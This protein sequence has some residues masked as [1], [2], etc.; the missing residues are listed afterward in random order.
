MYKRY[1][2]PTDS[3]KKLWK[4]LE[5]VIVIKL[6]DVRLNKM[7]FERIYI[8]TDHKKQQSTCQQNTCRVT[9]IEQ[10]KFI[11]LPKYRPIIK[12]KFEQSQL[13]SLAVISN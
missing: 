4:Y 3:A 12:L 6:S 9:T 1:S 13:L 10:F 2:K 5:R 7:V 11:L 8:R